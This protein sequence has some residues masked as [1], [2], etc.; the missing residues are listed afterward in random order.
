M[1][2]ALKK[3]ID[4]AVAEFPQLKGGIRRRKR[5]GFTLPSA[6]EPSSSS[7]AA[8]PAPA[9]AAATAPQTQAA[10]RNLADTTVQTLENTGNRIDAAVANAI[11]HIP[12]IAATSATVAIAT[13]PSILANIIGFINT[14]ANSI[15]SLSPSF[16]SVAQGALSL[17]G[18]GAVALGTAGS[19]IATPSGITTLALLIYKRRAQSNNRTIAEQAAADRALIEQRGADFATRQIDEFNAI[20]AAANQQATRYNR[21][22]LTDALGHL[23]RRT[24]E[25][26]EV[27]N[28]L[29]NLADTPVPPA[30]APAPLALPAPPSPQ[31]T[32][33]GLEDEENGED[34][35]PAAKK[36]KKKGGRR[37]RR[38]RNGKL[39]RRR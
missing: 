20:I 14:V 13:R 31:G 12:T 7:N 10:L 18:Q 6:D 2:D 5:G 9:P 32:K 16:G 26:I 17:A 21:I 39:T 3:E 19:Y 22:Q 29:A 33:R 15:P 27:A 4:A 37:T 34:N 24:P 28:I 30:P 36:G 38:N 23:P 25:E 35:K 11:A 8:A 1:N